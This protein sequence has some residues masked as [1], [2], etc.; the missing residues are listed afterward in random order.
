[1]VHSDLVEVE[2]DSVID[3]VQENKSQV[4][5]ETDELKVILGS[6]QFKLEVTD[7]KV[8]YLNTL[9]NHKF[10]NKE[11]KSGRP[12]DAE[13]FTTYLGQIELNGIENHLFKQFYTIQAAIEKHGHTVIVFVNKNGASYYDMEMPENLP[14]NMKN[15]SFR[16]KHKND[17]LIMK[18]EH[19]SDSDLVF[20]NTHITQ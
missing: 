1:M 8:K 10:L 16:F 7:P 20:R 3:V 6:L 4:E 15:G 9:I 18:I 19:V 5:S 11:V 14:L 2:N 12:D 17:T 13:Y